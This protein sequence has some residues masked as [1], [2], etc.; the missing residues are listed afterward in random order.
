VV[1][2]GRGQ[3]NIAVT[4]L[5]ELGIADMPVCSLAKERENVLGEK[6]V[7]RV[8]QPGR[9]NPV[10]IRDNGPALVLL[11]RAR[12]EAHRFANKTREALHHK[13]RL[14][15][16]L[17][18]LPGLGPVAARALLRKFGSVAGVAEATYAEIAAV[19]KVGPMRAKAAFEHLHPGVLQLPEYEDP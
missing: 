12:D 2:G 17:D 11:A 6:V 13:K 7:D 9:K 8:Y 16:E 4:V 19:P 14:R 1:D 15:S 18:G 5:R 10:T 3:L